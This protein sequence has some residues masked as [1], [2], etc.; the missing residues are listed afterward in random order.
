[1]SIFHQE[2]YRDSLY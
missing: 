1:M 2:D